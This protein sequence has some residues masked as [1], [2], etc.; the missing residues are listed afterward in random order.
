MNNKLDKELIR[1]IL[2]NLETY[3]D[4][5][6]TDEQVKYHLHLM[7]DGE[8]IHATKL[9]DGNETYYIQLTMSDKGYDLLSHITNDYVWDSVKDKL[10]DKDL[11]VNDVPM[12]IIK[13]LAQETL[14]EM[15]N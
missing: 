9:Q 8:L 6:V 4:V 3:K 12:D 14:K 1:D 2:L 5:Q 15:F 13:W 7:E 11:T 10:Q